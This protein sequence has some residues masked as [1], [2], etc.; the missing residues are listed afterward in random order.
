VVAW[1]AA[2]MSMARLFIV[3]LNGKPETF[4]GAISAMPNNGEWELGFS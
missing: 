2:W 3:C 1:L 4:A